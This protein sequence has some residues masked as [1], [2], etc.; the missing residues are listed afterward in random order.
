MPVSSFSSRT[1]AV[2]GFSWPPLSIPPCAITPALSRQVDGRH[3]ETS[4]SAAWDACMR[5]LEN[6]PHVWHA[7]ADMLCRMYLWHLPCA[8]FVV[9]SPV[10]TNTRK[11]IAATCKSLIGNS[12]D[13]QKHKQ[14]L[15]DPHTILKDRAFRRWNWRDQ[16]SCK[17]QSGI[18]HQAYS[19]AA[20]VLFKI[21]SRRRL[22]GFTRVIQHFTGRA[23]YERCPADAY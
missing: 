9:H 7:Q 19:H 2:M 6:A 22:S 15:R 18:V 1:A 5:G 14:K 20:S 16:P 4:S 21:P 3:P 12:T 13:W 10:W 8:M 11:L 23:L 17:D